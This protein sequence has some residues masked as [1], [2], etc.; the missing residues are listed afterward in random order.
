[1]AGDILSMPRLAAGI[2]KRVPFDYAQGRLSTALRFA[3]DDKCSGRLKDSRALETQGRRCC[4]HSAPQ[5]A[6][7]PQVVD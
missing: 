4:L 7:P 3:Q 5:A 2:K 6:S 1:M